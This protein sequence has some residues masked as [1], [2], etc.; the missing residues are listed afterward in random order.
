[1]ALRKTDI[2]RND[3]PD[4]ESDANARPFDPVIDAPLEPIRRV[5][6][7]EG[8]ILF[9]NAARRYLGMSGD[10]FKAAYAAG[11]FDDDPCDSNFVM[12]RM[13]L[14]FAED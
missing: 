5:S 2:A 11:K 10:E 4:A 12:V 6:P 13:L 9:D 7:A 8:R 3:Q 14:P 1:M